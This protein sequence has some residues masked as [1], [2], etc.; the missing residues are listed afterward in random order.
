MCEL[1][2]A[3]RA[4]TLLV[5]RQEGQLACKKL[6]G[7]VLAW[8]SVW[9]EVQTCVWPSWCR[10][11]SLSLASVKYRLVLPFW[12]RLTWTDMDKGLLNGCVWVCGLLEDQDQVPHL[13][14]VSER[15]AYVQWKLSSSEPA[16]S[17]S[18]MTV[19]DSAADNDSPSSSLTPR[20]AHTHHQNATLRPVA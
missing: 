20:W 19:A 7:G 16:A 9:N 8:S 12:Y 4:L 6:S 1:L 17:L 10:C 2:C 13:T 5:G 11:H 14:P 15:S 3:F 18:D